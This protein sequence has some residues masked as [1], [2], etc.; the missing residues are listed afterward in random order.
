MMNIADELLVYLVT[1][2][3]LLICMLSSLPFYEAWC[4]QLIRGRWLL[5]LRRTLSKLLIWSRARTPPHM[6]LVLL[7]WTLDISLPCTSWSRLGMSCVRNVLHCLCYFL[8]IRLL[9]CLLSLSFFFCL[10]LFCPFCFLLVEPKNNIYLDFL[11]NKFYI[12]LNY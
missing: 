9:R 11:M 3:S 6:S 1:S 4:L 7:L 2:T 5:S 10:Y 12:N 8:L